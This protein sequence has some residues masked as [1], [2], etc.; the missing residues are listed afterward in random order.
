MNLLRTQIQTFAMFHKHSSSHKVGE[1]SWEIS[2]NF[3]YDEIGTD[4]AQDALLKKTKHFDWLLNTGNF[5]F[6][7]ETILRDCLVDM[8]IWM[9]QCTLVV[10]HS[11]ITGWIMVDD[12]KLFLE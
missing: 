8:L 3:R 11:H 1:E 10:L 5:V 12:I 2:Y 9:N 4:E 6:N 7:R